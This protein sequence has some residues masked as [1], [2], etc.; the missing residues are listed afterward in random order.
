MA[1]VKFSGFE[2]YFKDFHPHTLFYSFNGVGKTTFAGRTGLRTILLDCGDAGVVTLRG[3]KNLKIVRITSVSQYLDV[4]EKVIRLADKIDL[5]VVDTLT[6]LQSRAIREVKGKRGEMNQRKWGQASGKVIECISETSNFPKDI[7]YLAQEKRKRKEEEEG[8][9]QVIS[10][11]LTPSVREFLSGCVD[12]VGRM[13]IEDEKRK[14]SFV[15]TDTVEAKDRG[16]LFP[17]V[18]TCPDVASWRKGYSLIRKRVVDS[19]HT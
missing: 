3:A 9:I 17:K 19:I 1:D 8:T 14:I 11:S 12:W 2:E 6:G 4:I 5:L 7:I 10:P 18:I 13:Y 15:L 16:D